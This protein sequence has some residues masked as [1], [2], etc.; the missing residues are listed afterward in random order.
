MKKNGN[1]ITVLV[2]VIALTAAAIF[3]VGYITTPQPVIL[4][5]EAV[6]TTYKVSSKLAGRVDSLGVKLGDN[7]A[8][9]DFIFRLSTPEVDAKLEQ[10][11]ALLS[12][13][14]AQAMLADSGLR[15]EEISAIESQYNKA[16]AGLTLAQSTFDRVSGLYKDGVVSA[17]SYDEAKANLEAMQSNVDA[18]LAQYIMAKEGARS[19]NKSAAQAVVRQA[20]GGVAEVASYLKDAVQYAEVSGEVSSVIAERGELVGSGYPVVSIVDISDIWFSFN[21]KESYLPYIREDQVLKVRVPALARDIDVKVYYIAVQAQYATRT[22][23]RAD[24]EFDVRTFEVRMRPVESQASL[25]PGMTAL[26]DWNNI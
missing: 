11:Q 26:I 22:A 9:G 19:E 17:Q 3:I 16:K 21:I 12:A 23:T 13:A 1:I 2:I 18:A 25:R 4:Q 7:V 10:A 5:G 24:G 8:K 15:P 20:K 14:G 6:A